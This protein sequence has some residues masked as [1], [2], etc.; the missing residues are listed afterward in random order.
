MPIK[1]TATKILVNDYNELETI[2]SS[3]EE[4]LSF[5]SNNH[6]DFSCVIEKHIKDNFVLVKTLYLEEYCN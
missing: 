3:L 1:T 4:K 5:Y 2:A 6:P